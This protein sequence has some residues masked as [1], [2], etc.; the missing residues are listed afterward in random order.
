MSIVRIQKRKNPYVQID[1][2]PLNDERLTWEARGVLG[3]LLSKPDT[4]EVNIKDLANKSPNG[5]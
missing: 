2:R 1:H 3:Y 4:W 5:S